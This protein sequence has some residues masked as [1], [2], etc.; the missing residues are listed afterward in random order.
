MRETKSGKDRNLEELYSAR[1]NNSVCI[2]E[3]EWEAMIKAIYIT[4]AEAY[5]LLKFLHDLAEEL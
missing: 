5:P 1:I 2:W 3:H 4:E